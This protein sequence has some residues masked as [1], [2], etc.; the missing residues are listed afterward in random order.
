MLPRTYSP[1]LAQHESRLGEGSMTQPL[2]LFLFVR[3]CWDLMD[4]IL[5]LSGVDSVL[6]LHSVIYVLFGN[7]AKRYPP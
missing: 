6:I 3:P 5:H 1:D 4:H 7:E 2:L